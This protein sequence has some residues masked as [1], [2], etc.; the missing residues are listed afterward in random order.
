MHAVAWPTQSVSHPERGF[1][2][3][4]TPDHTYHV[5]ERVINHLPAWHA[6][7]NSTRQEDMNMLYIA[8]CLIVAWF[9]FLL[10]SLA[11]RFFMASAVLLF[12]VGMVLMAGAK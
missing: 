10:F 5:Y 3:R 4:Y 11:P 8:A 7:C 2:T 9:S 6:I 1:V 12:I